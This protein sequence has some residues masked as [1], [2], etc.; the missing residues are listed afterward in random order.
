MVVVKYNNV[1]TNKNLNNMW[2][3]LIKLTALLLALTLLLTFVYRAMG[4]D[5]VKGRIVQGVLFGLIAVLGMYMPVNYAPGIIFDPRSVIISMAGFFGGPIAAI[6]AM[7]IAGGYR[8]SLGG[9][10][11]IAGSLVVF[12]SAGSGIAAYYLRKRFL[13]SSSALHF[14]LFGLICHFI[15]MFGMLA[16]PSEVM[17]N[18]VNKLSLPFFIIYPPVTIFVGYLLADIERKYELELKLR[19]ST[20]QLRTL[21]NTAPDLIWLKD[22]NGA[23]LMCNQLVETYL[24]VSESELKGTT[25]YNYIDKE[26]ADLI[27]ASDL[28]AIESGGE[29]VSEHWVTYAEDQ[30]KVLLEITKT[31][32]YDSVQ[33]LIGVLGVAH[34]ITKRSEVEAK[35]RQSA[36]VFESTLEG[37]FITDKNSKILDVNQSFIDITGYERH[38]AIGVTPTILSSGKHDKDFFKSMW[39]SINQ[40]GQWRGEIWNKRKDQKIFPMWLTISTVKNEENDVINYVSVFTDITEIKK[41][42]SE[43]NFLAHHDALTSLP[44]R[45]F[46]NQKLDASLSHAKRI[47]SKLAILFIDLDRFKNINDSFGH[48]AGD[49]LLIQLS[50]RLKK[51][52]RMEDT[53]CR[54]SGDEF[55]I[56][57]EDIKSTET[58]VHAIEKIMDVFS[59]SFTIEEHNIRIT[60][61]VGISLYPMDGNSA[62]D[63]IRNADAAMYRAKDE[64]RNTYQFYT[65]DLT[66][67]AFERVI[68]ETELREALAN[69]EFYLHYQPQ[70]DLQTKRLIGLEVLLRWR[71]PRLELVPPDQFIPLAEDSGLINPIGEWVLKE[72]CQQA[73]KW[74]D[75]GFSFG[76]IAVNISGVQVNK[77]QLPE[78]VRRTLL[79][80]GLPAASLE[81]EVTESFIMKQAEK[82]IIQLNELRKLGVLL[83]IDDFGTGYSSLSYLKRLPVHKLKIDRSFVCDIIEDSDDRA[84]INAIIA[85]GNSLGLAVI[86][87]G[88]ENIE[89]EQYL[90]SSGC[91]EAQ[92]FFYSKPVTPDELLKKYI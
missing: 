13:I 17:W 25:D 73:K 44:N 58:V 48:T 23:Y 90:L 14:F 78:I 20:A 29:I 30:R 76:R 62:T 12:L 60:A 54:I 11:A 31:P 79:E 69:K 80:T 81:L 42:Q 63:L 43:L 1:I 87:E 89:Q 92:G 56:L 70:V 27:Q 19:A 84:I 66:T 75:Q 35:L 32:V 22:V 18:V 83:S 5:S 8:Y 61:S 47:E 64:G 46:F 2:I 77:G 86:A 55:I 33:Q 57:F 91:N 15:A 52:V 39:H 7:V 68:M 41:S 72:A 24:G 26:Q 40:T 74:V 3:E 65:R 85:M 45:L 37:V 59:S 36:K 82:A 50:K 4:K 49:H 28:K 6:P 10:G 53:L 16:L 21:F 34:D 71:H 67:K 38:E 9:A 88:V 51:T